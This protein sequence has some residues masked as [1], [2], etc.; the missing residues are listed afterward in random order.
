MVDPASAG[1][2]PQVAYTLAETLR[3]ELAGD[4]GYARSAVGSELLLAAA[5]QPEELDR[6]LDV[7]RRAN[8]PRPTDLTNAARRRHAEQQREAA[9]RHQ[10]Q[11]GADRSV[12]GAIAQAGLPSLDA[13][14][15]CVMP[16]PF[17]VRDGRIVGLGV[18]EDGTDVETEVFPAVVVPTRRLHRDD[19][20]VDVELAWIDG[21]RW[22]RATVSRGQIAATR[23]IPDLVA[24][25]MPIPFDHRRAVDYLSAYDRANADRIPRTLLTTQLGWQPSGDDVAGHGFLLGADLLGDH[26]HIDVRPDPRIE[27]ATADYR[28]RGTLQGWAEAVRPLAGYASV[29]VAVYAA[30]AAVLLRP[31]ELGNAAIEFAS[32]TSSGKSSL[33]RLATSCWGWRDE[34]R[35]WDASS[36]GF[37]RL[38][39]A[40]SD[41]GALVLDDTSTARSF[42]GRS[43]VQST[44]YQYIAGSSRTRGTKESRSTERAQ[45]WHGLLISSGEQPVGDHGDAEG[46]S[47][48]ILSIAPDLPVDPEVGDL[49]DRT[50][51][52]LAR[53]HGHVVPRIVQWIMDHRGEWSR[54]RD[55]YDAAALIVRR[56]V[57]N[58]PGGRAA[59][60]VGL[61]EV[62]AYVAHEAVP[63]LPWGYSPLL[64]Q[65][66]MVRLFGAAIEQQQIA[67]DQVEQ[68]WQALVSIFDANPHR[69]WADTHDKNNSARQPPHGWLGRR[70]HRADQQGER[71]I[72]F[73]TAAFDELIRKIK[74]ARTRAEAQTVRLRRDLFDRGLLRVNERD[75]NAWKEPKEPRYYSILT[76]EARDERR[77]AKA[78]ALFL[79]PSRSKERAA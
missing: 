72:D 26:D 9:L 17:E 61:L 47:A 48:R 52:A 67:S 11:R 59:H 56:Q 78:L 16:S 68:I 32:R 75:R 42:A 37:E 38:A 66:E 3:A 18:A 77:A 21:R 7:L 79:S 5:A 29:R 8:V 24:L 33:L 43:T 34:L 27:D 71:Y 44:I 36:V 62:A 70:D 13:V 58:G 73:H 69:F 40:V 31:L 46:A 50:K 55:M 4:P 51:L 10:V 2:P 6:C 54:L 63:E 45:T 25:G 14:E 39:A 49:L 60:V 53:H 65:P 12:A 23:H 20:R 57:G 28:R 74:G 22:H 19:G 64:R 1:P 30:V 15:S 35:S 41:A 76:T